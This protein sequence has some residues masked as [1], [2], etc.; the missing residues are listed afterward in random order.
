ML[1]STPSGSH[2]SQPITIWMFSESLP[3]MR[4]LQSAAL[5]S[6]LSSAGTVRGPVVVR[7]IHAVAVGY[8]MTCSF[9]EFSWSIVALHSTRGIA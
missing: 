9:G 5:P 8:S 4:N 3:S 2:S 1:S 7:I 6:Y